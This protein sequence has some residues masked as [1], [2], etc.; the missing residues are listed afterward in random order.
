[1]IQPP[2]ETVGLEVP[3]TP[4]RAQGLVGW[5]QRFWQ[6]NPTSKAFQVLVNMERFEGFKEESF[7]NRFWGNQT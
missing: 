3:R 6:K 2:K 1:M 4:P 5:P 7:K